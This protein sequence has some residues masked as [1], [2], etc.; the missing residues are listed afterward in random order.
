MAYVGLIDVSF[1]PLLLATNSLLMKRPTGWF[2]FF[3]FGAVSGT[4][5]AAVEYEA[6]RKPVLW[7]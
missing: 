6:H 3:P 1:W 7:I 4:S 5:I 2:H